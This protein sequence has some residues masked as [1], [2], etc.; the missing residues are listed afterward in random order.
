MC[1]K[2][3]YDVVL[4]ELLVAQEDLLPAEDGGLR[5]GL[6]GSGAGVGGGQHLSLGR[7]GNA[8]H[9]LIRGLRSR[10]RVRTIPSLT[11]TFS[12]NIHMDIFID[13]AW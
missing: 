9:H 4:D 8:S 5:P 2:S 7:F 12:Q 13:F 11:C 6:E 3:F 10:R 1:M